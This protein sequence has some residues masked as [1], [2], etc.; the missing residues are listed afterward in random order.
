MPDTRLARCSVDRESG[1]AIG[2][3]AIRLANVLAD[4]F[5]PTIESIL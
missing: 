1:E 2:D 3:D 4:C 5:A